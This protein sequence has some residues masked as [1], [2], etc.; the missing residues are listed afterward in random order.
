MVIDENPEQKF[1]LADR[2]IDTASGQMFSESPHWPG[3][4]HATDLMIYGLGLSPAE[5][6][7]YLDDRNDAKP[8]FG[9]G[10]AYEGSSENPLQMAVHPVDVPKFVQR[11]NAY[12]L[13]I[14][15]AVPIRLR[16]GIFEFRRPRK[17]EYGP[18]YDVLRE[19]RLLEHHVADLADEIAAD[20]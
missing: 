15:R 13:V 10:L 4:V 8:N 9:L 16:S 7:D 19:H 14:E 3:L 11:V 17:A 1:P 2:F 20:G 18:A 6:A 5:G 12:R